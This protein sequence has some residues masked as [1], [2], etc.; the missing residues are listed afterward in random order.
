MLWQGSIETIPASWSL[1]DGT[2]GTPDL[3]DKFLFGNSVGTPPIDT[4]GVSSHDHDFTGD[5]HDHTIPA[6]SAF[7]AGSGFSDT[8]NTNQLI[9]TT[10]SKSHLP[11]WYSLCYIMFVGGD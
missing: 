6:G 1:C 3:R 8:T 11:P 5:G 2:N 7:A 4:G 9:G 10:D